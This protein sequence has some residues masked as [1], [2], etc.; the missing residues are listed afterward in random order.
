MCKLIIDC[1]RTVG[2]LYFVSAPDCL[3]DRTTIFINPTSIKILEI[4]LF[5]FD[6]RLFHADSSPIYGALHDTQPHIGR[7]IVRDIKWCIV[8]FPHNPLQDLRQSCV[9]IGVRSV[10]DNIDKQITN[11]LMGI[12]SYSASHDN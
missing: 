10:G 8:I 11:V 7:K 9:M 2:T 6:Y 1:P 3:V 4:Y 5:A 12:N